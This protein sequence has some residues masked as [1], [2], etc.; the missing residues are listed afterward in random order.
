MDCGSYRKHAEGIHQKYYN[1]MHIAAQNQGHSS[2]DKRLYDQ[3]MKLLTF[4]LVCP[5]CSHCYQRVSKSGV[6]VFH[7]SCRNSF[8]PFCQSRQIGPHED[9]Q[10]KGLHVHHYRQ[11]FFNLKHVKQ[12]T[13]LDLL[14]RNKVKVSDVCSKFGKGCEL[15]DLKMDGK[16]K[17]CPCAEKVT[18][19]N[20]GICDRHYRECLIQLINANKLDLVD[21]ASENELLEMFRRFGLAL[22]KVKASYP[23][24]AAREKTSIYRERLKEMLPLSEDEEAMV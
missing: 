16:L 23:A 14:R 20:P 19:K 18:Y 7:C 12:T 1:K 2:T 8:C 10:I 13:L 24:S 22:P 17:V 15:P 5:K 9:C 6:F 4:H 3:M 11:C 21:V